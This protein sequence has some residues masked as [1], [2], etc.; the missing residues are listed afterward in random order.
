MRHLFYFFLTLAVLIFNIGCSET[1]S[2]IKSTINGSDSTTPTPSPT[3]SLT[4]TPSPTP[5][6]IT[7]T[8]PSQNSSVYVGENILTR[9]LTISGTC[10][11]N[12]TLNWNLPSGISVLNAHCSSTGTLST[13]IEIAQ[14]VSGTKRLELSLSSGGSETIDIDVRSCPLNFILVPSNSS[15]GVNTFCLPKYEAKAMTNSGSLVTD[16]NTTP[17]DPTLHY[18]SFQKNGLPWTKVT[19]SNI[20]NECSS[21]G[22]KYRLITNKEWQTVA[23]NIESYSQNW[24]TNTPGTGKMYKGHTDGVISA[25][26]ISEGYGVTGS[27]LLASADDSSPYTGTGNDSST[28]AD[29]KRTLVLNNG[30]VIWDLAGNAKEWVDL[31]GLGSS[32]SYTGTTPSSAYYEYSSSQFTNMIPTTVLS[33]G[34]TLSLD[35]FRPFYFNLTAASNNVGRIYIQSNGSTRTLKGVSRGGHFTANHQNGIFGADL[36]LTLVSTSSSTSF[37][38]VYVP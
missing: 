30:E 9:K 28:G 12:S 8:S 17:V 24:D 33:A 15:F 1:S 38:C 31:D 36:D 22:S 14:N 10:T 5:T 26:A 23:R 21:L 20:L 32:L 18:P 25:S 27:L 3:S 37:R 7:F 34:G 35:D 6:R 29:Q 13:E 16:P 4:P 11:A 2:S 19:F